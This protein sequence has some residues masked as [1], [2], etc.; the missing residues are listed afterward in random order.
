MQLRKPVPVSVEDHD[1]AGLR[2]VHAHFD[3]RCR[4]QNRRG[5]IREIGHDLLL[6][7]VIVA[8]GQRRETDATELRQ[9]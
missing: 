6:G 8:A 9:R 4:H 1:A 7:R 5:P 2:H 3:D